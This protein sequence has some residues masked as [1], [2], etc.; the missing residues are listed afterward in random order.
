MSR[1]FGLITSRWVPLLPGGSSG[2][3]D[4]NPIDRRFV[5]DCFTAEHRFSGVTLSCMGKAADR[6][7]AFGTFEQ[8]KPDVET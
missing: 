2:R 4:Q 7:V 3:T 1:Q 5:H 8:I 6:G